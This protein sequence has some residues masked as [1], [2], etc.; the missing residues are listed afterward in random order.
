MPYTNLLFFML[1]LLIYATYLPS[2]RGDLGLCVLG[3]LCFGAGFYVFTWWGFRHVQRKAQDAASSELPVE[4]GGEAFERRCVLLALLI[5]LSLVYSFGLKNI[6]W[7]AAWIKESPF[8]DLIAGFL[9]F[10]GLLAVLWSNAFQASG[11]AIGRR[12]YL[13]SQARLNAPILLPVFLL[14]FFQDVLRL[15][16]L[17][18]R[19]VGESFFSWDFVIFPAFLVVLTVFYPVVVRVIWRCRP[20]PPGAHR[21]QLEALCRKAGLKIAGI[22]LWPTFLGRS[23]TAGI[24]GFVG[25][26]RYLFVT[27]ELLQILDEEEL[28][29]VVAHEAGH[30]KK[31]HM[32]FYAA[33]VLG[34]PLLVFVFSDLFVLALDGYNDILDPYLG[35]WYADPTIGSL[36]VLCFCAL[37]MVLYLRLFFG[38][39]SRNF[40]R[41]A[42]LFVFEVVGHPYALISSLEKIAYYGRL[43][44]HQANWHHF[45]IGQRVRF[46]RECAERREHI[47]QHHRKVR[48]IKCV[49][50][51]VLV[52]T[53][54]LLGV[55]NYP[56][57]RKPVEL[58]LMENKVRRVLEKTEGDPKLK[59]V[60]AD[61]LLEK[62]EYREA[63]ALYQEVIK[64][65]PDDAAA[66]N[67]LAW[68]YA[69]ADDQT[70]RDESMA[71]TLALEAARRDPQPHVLDTLAEAYFVNGNR[72]KALETIDVAISLRPQDL[73]YYEKQRRK[74]E[75][76]EEAD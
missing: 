50:L 67:N 26:L 76:R 44:V 23:I 25:R 38:V 72:Q 2:D 46:L 56:V 39:L 3:S 40:E 32:D 29:S 5:Y 28:A 7:R 11:L 27:P 37:G 30:V 61:V 16:P 65:N 35:S 20:I 14:T 43:N 36:A 10:L 49:V 17:P 6:I 63:T 62:K 45:G 55:L 4:G 19:R 34:F 22:Y 42:D 71:L 68:L 9:P 54:L 75:G 69:T 41:Q 8:L 74:F 66:L 70:V 47:V 21:D 73:W 51:V 13:V 64:S 18:W 58:S 12:D 53:F 24:S 33:L 1:A 52:M 57:T 59:R 48:S 31:R 60:L 15:V